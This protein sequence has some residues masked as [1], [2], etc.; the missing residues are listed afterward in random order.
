MTKFLLKPAK[1]VVR[2]VTTWPNQLPVA[3]FLY[4]LLQITSAA[5]EPG[6]QF[7]QTEPNSSTTATTTLA[8]LTSKDSTVINNASTEQPT[9]SSESPP[10]RIY[11]QKGT[12]V[13][14]SE[15]EGEH[16]RAPVAPPSTGVQVQIYI[17]LFIGILPAAFGGCLW[18]MKHLRSSCSRPDTKRD[19]G[20]SSSD[21]DKLSHSLVKG[22]LINGVPLDSS[23]LHRQIAKRAEMSTNANAQLYNSYRSK[24]IKKIYTLEMP[25]CFEMIEVIG[26]GN[27]GQ[28]WKAKMYSKRKPTLVAIKTNKVNANYEEQEDLLKE[29][30]IMLQLGSHPN[31]VRLIGCCTENEPYYLV[32]EYISMGKLLSFLRHHRK[33]GA[34]YFEA[35]SDL[36]PLTA[37]IHNN[38]YLTYCNNNAYG[39]SEINHNRTQPTAL[40]DNLVPFDL[41]QFAYQISK[42][43]EFISSHGIIH[44]DLAARNVLIDENKVCKIADFGL[45]RSIRDKEGDTYEMKHAGQMPIRWMSPEALSMGLFSTKSDVWAFGILIWEICTLGSTPYIGMS[46]Q[47]VISFIRQGNIAE[48]PE[49]CSDE[50][51]D[52]MK[53]CWAYKAEDRFTFTD[54]KHHL[55]KMLLDIK[56]EKSNY[57]DLEHFNDSIYYFNAS[58]PDEK[59]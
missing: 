53:S 39:Y 42:G 20:G 18:W 7:N 48:Q 27:F 36:P 26:Q 29:L 32:L 8:P 35:D 12:L 40:Q 37:V 10:T 33:D 45:S 31:V 41:I 13:V 51:Y 54:V 56:E 19:A 25:R 2:P 22:D 3:V 55:A 4:L 1:P 52:L 5:P 6:E 30:D 47:E 17:I 59:L 16:S 21:A 15:R 38:N 58:A 49:H 57:I 11:L 34:N 28:V 23:L 50:L 43:M 44:R 24:L 9:S 46:A 14:N